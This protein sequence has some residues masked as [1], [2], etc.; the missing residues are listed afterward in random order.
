MATRVFVLYVA[1]LAAAAAA[2]AGNGHLL[3]GIGAVNSSLGGAGAGLPTDAISALHANP[4]LLVRLDGYEVEISAEV[5]SD[6]PRIDSLGPL[7]AR[8]GQRVRGRAEA[9]HELG[10]IPAV[11]LAH[12]RSGGRLAWG[13][14]L[15]GVAGFRTD[16]RADADDPLFQPPPN[17]YGRVHTDLVITKIPV[18]IAWQVNDRLAVGAELAVFQGRFAVSPFPVAPADCSRGPGGGVDLADCYFPPA[19]NL[20]SA[21]A[22]TPQVGFYYELSAEWSVGGSWLGHQSY[23]D[24]EW[25]SAVQ[26]PN[27]GDFGAPRRFGEN[28]D[29]PETVVLGVGYRP[30]PRLRLALDARWVHYSNVS[31]FSGRG[32]EF[33]G[34]EPRLRGIGWENIWIGMLGVEYDAS[35]QVTLR[36]GLNFNESPIAPQRVFQSLG[37]PSTYQ[38]HYTLGAGIAA[39]PRLRIDLGAYYVPRDEKS[40]PLLSFREADGV[41]EGTEFTISDTIV[42][43]LVSISARF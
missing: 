20:V 37:T 2:W 21:Y 5:F 7:A 14:G 26:N 1:L 12:H 23:G 17:G 10:V 6:A 8:G 36:G 40:G 34:G 39:G 19:S 28:V 35:P 13:F 25:N 15:L 22:F 29:G 43:G 38:Q 9:D 31:G 4:A 16:W 27:R 42:S 32:F 24:Y 41:V 18:A 11:G 3:H 30:S 33:V